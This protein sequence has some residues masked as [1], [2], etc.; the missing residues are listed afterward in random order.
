[1]AYDT[2]FEGDHRETDI[3]LARPTR[4]LSRAT[5]VYA[6]PLPAWRQA[7]LD[8]LNAPY[9]RIRVVGATFGWA[10]MSYLL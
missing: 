7:Q 9:G 4:A 6:D 2:A 8:E 3:S 5:R 1:M 10:A